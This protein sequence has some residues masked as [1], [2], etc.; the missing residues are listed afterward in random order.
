MQSVEKHKMA[1]VK[2]CTAVNSA[3]IS[4][5]AKF[6]NTE[7]NDPR[8]IRVIRVPSYVGQGV[9]VPYIK[10]IMQRS[11]EGDANKISSEQRKHEQSAYRGHVYF[12]IASEL[13]FQILLY[14]LY[15]R[16]R[17]HVNNP[18]GYKVC[19]RR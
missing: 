15:P 13:H 19:Y 10:L 4:V 16:V 1:S 7:N 11:T 5:P 8:Y 2:G 3:G 6:D 12:L 17:F 14:I 9:I 18:A